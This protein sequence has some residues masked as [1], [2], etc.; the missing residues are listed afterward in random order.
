MA[1]K[2]Y[3]V[4]P[5]TGDAGACR[6]AKSPCPFGGADAHYTSPEAAQAA[7]AEKE[8]K[9]TLAVKTWRKKP[10]RLHAPTQPPAGGGHGGG[11]GASTYS[12]PKPPP[13]PKASPLQ[14]YGGHGG[15][16]H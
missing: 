8:E 1:N 4:N 9:K 11:H 10:T 15:H 3:H 12:P 13:L 7:W 16:G 5:Q 14:S 2:L 6:A